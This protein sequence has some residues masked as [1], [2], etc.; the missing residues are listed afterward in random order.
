MQQQHEGSEKNKCQAPCD[1]SSSPLV[2][3]LVLLK[4]V[5]DFMNFATGIDVNAPNRYEE[6]NAIS[7]TSCG[8]G[9]WHVKL[10]CVI[11]FA[12]FA[13]FVA[14]SGDPLLQAVVMGV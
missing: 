3:G 11:L 6:L 5:V 12:D 1:T 13:G 14:L 4:D 7:G 10:S 8:W 9:D 2:S